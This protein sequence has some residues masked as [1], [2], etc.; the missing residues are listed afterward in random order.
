VSTESKTC[1]DCGRRSQ[2]SAS[3]G[4]VYSF[5]GPQPLCPLCQRH[6][7][8]RRAK[9]MWG[10][11]LSLL[12]A[13][14]LLAALGF[15]RDLLWMGMAWAWLM[16]S[17]YLS[18]FPHELGHAFMARAVG[19]RP[20]A[21][22]VGEPG[23]ARK[24]ELFGI[25]LLLGKLPQ[26]GLMFFEPSDLRWPRLRCIAITAA[27]ALTNLLL[28]WC[29]LQLALAIDVPF[30]QSFAKSGLLV[31][32]AAN[33][34][35]AFVNLWPTHSVTPVGRFPNDGLKL[36]K[37]LTGSPLSL[38]ENR[39]A[40]SQLRMYFAHIDGEAQKV[41]DETEVAEKR[42]GAAPWIE[43]ARSAALCSLHR[44][45]DA[46]TVLTPLLESD[47]VDPGTRGLAANNMAWA[48]F[49]LDDPAHDA[50]CLEHSATAM[51]AVPWH[52]AVVITRAI[53]LAAHASAGDVRA[54]EARSLLDTLASVPMENQSRSA[55]A[56]ARGLLAVVHGEFP[57]AR[58]HLK[59]ARAWF[60]PGMAGRVLEAR[61]PNP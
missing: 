6:R 42:W 51:E 28:G 37:M 47:A 57:D 36:L 48:L 49:L 46:C 19:Y 41:L 60:D 38:E 59:T 26:A 7:R 35:L 12:I 16:I 61:L 3:F 13:V 18:I 11:A 21:I 52:P 25:R 15:T 29:V 50:A 40:A 34:I 55:A 43:V 44:P 22:V 23:P 56:V 39:R 4:T 20:L 8:E 30:H 33:G 2:W 24:R 27:G 54:R 10:A 45:A 31:F 58:E 9:R 1:S 14:P 17:M 53:V 32:A 5:K